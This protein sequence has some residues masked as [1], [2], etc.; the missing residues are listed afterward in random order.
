[1]KTRGEG[2]EGYDFVIDMLDKKEAWGGVPI[3]GEDF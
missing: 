1:M 3:D 2:N